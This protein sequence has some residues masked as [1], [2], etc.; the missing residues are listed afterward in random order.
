[1]HFPEKWFRRIGVPPPK[2][3]RG[4]KSDNKAIFQPFYGHAHLSFE[5]IWG[6][7]FGENG[8]SSLFWT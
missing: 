6:L 2:F 4:L 8:G 3:R 1:M 7:G 5:V